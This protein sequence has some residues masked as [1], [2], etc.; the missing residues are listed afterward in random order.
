MKKMLIMIG[1]FKLLDR[2]VK[3]IAACFQFIQN[4]SKVEASDVWSIYKLSNGLTSEQKLDTQPHW[5][6]PY[7]IIFYTAYIH[8]IKYI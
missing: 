5:L 2:R 7:K 6:I 3:P 4:K 8:L 1:F